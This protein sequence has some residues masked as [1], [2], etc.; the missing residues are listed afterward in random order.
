MDSQ[1]RGPGPR[2]A[3]AEIPP[4]PAEQQP[5]RPPA[6]TSFQD[7][8]D[9]ALERGEAVLHAQLLTDIRLVRFEPGHIELRLNENA[10]ENIVSRLIRFLNENTALKWLV[11]I[12]HDTGAP[13]LVEQRRA[14]VAAKTKEVETHP[15]VREVMRVFP[16]AAITDVRPGKTKEASDGNGD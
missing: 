4:R 13:T 11:G 3:L 10:P 15:L 6:P 1:P 14:A 8:A 9:L 12:S 7:V 16:G 5:A 2:A